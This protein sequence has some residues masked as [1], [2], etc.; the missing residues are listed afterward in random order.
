MPPN[1]RETRKELSVPI[2]KTF[3]GIP[4]PGR[5]RNA[6]LAGGQIKIRMLD[7]LPR[8]GQFFPGS[9]RNT[10][11]GVQLAFTNLHQGELACRKKR[12]QQQKRIKPA[13]ASIIPPSA[14][15]APGASA[16]PKAARIL[17][18]S[19]SF[20]LIQI[21]YSEKKAEILPGTLSSQ[22]FINALVPALQ[23]GESGSLGV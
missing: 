1:P 6:R 13:T 4:T 23:H 21:I 15:P 18:G 12:I 14:G 8:P 7:S 11:P 9:G 16:A 3:P 10:F 22:F 19:G 20:I 5:K 17:R 2:Q